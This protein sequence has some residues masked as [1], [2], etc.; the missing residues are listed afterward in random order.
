M[1]GEILTILIV[2]TFCAILCYLADMMVKNTKR[3]SKIN[4]LEY[5]RT[6]KKLGIK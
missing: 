2:V 5:K 4:Y 6:L 3:Q 1:I